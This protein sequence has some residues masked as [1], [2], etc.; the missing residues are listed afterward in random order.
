[1]GPSLCIFA[2]MWGGLLYGMDIGTTSFV[3]PMLINPP[4][5]DDHVGSVW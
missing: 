1:M 5:Q 2:P 4:P 3:L